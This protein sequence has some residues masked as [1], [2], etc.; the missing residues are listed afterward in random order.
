MNKRANYYIL[1]L[2]IAAILGTGC[3]GVGAAMSL[4]SFYCYG[5]PDEC[6]SAD[7]GTNGVQVTK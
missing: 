4:G 2:L 3:V 1:L 5:R 7:I 6:K